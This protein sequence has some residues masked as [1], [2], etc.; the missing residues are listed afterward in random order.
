MIIKIR[1]LLFRAHN[2]KFETFE[3]R[4]LVPNFENDSIEYALHGKQRF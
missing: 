3:N 1:N 4:K 2:T